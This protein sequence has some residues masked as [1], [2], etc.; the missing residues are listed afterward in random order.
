MMVK[1]NPQRVKR[2]EQQLDAV[3]DTGVCIG[4]I[5]KAA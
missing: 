4:G 2:R 5:Y 3:L 1:W